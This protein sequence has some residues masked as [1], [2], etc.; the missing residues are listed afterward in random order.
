MIDRRL[1]K[2]RLSV[3]HGVAGSGTGRQ[4]TLPVMT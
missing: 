1:H 2:T 4:A 3:P